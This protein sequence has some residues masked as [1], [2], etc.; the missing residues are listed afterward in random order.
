MELYSTYEYGD[1]P[2]TGLT[3]VSISATHYGLQSTSHEVVYYERHTL[4]GNR[5]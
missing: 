1:H 4:P 5:A 3:V 2:V